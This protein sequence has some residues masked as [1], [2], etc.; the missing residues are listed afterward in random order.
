MTQPKSQ[1]RLF[2]RVDSNYSSRH[3]MLHRNCSAKEQ[4][5]FQKAVRSVP[6]FSSPRDHRQ[7]LLQLVQPQH[8]R[9]N[10]GLFAMGRA[11]QFLVREHLFF[12]KYVLLKSPP[13][14]RNVATEAWKC[15]RPCS[16]VCAHSGSPG[17]PRS[18]V[19]QLTKHPNTI[20]KLTSQ[21]EL[22]DSELL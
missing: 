16:E 18:A 21:F 2:I 17:A 19:R 7:H 20:R 12:P 6:L 8:F 5:R 4:V 14:K 13:P 22:R 10:M 1:R 11:S 15:T 9:F 3:C